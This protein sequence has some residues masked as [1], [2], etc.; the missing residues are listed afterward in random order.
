MKQALFICALTVCTWA[1][2]ANPGGGG[3]SGP[4]SIADGTT[5]ANKAWVGSA[6]EMKFNVLNFPSNFQVSNF[7][8]VQAVSQ[9]GAWSIAFSAPQH[10]ICDSGCG[11]AGDVAVVNSTTAG[12]TKLAV[13]ADPITFASTQNVN[14]ANSSIAV[15]GTFW[16]A[17]QPVSGPLTDTQLRATPVP[18]SG[19]F[20]QA[21]QPVSGPLTDAQ[22]RASSVNVNCAS[23]CSS[24]TVSQTYM[25]T[26]VGSAAA[27]SKD[28]IN[29]FNGVGSG[30]VIKLMKVAVAQGNAAAVTTGLV[31]SITM[32]KTSSAGATCTAITVRPLD[33]TNSAVPAQVTAGTNCTTD[34]TV[35]W[36]WKG[37]HIMT[38]ESAAVADEDF[39]YVYDDGGKQPITLREGEGLLLKTT[40]LNAVGA[41][42]INIEFT[43]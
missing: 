17:T 25:A 14:V 7:P 19:T 37:C 20:W 5:P 8:A 23:G 16:Q 34:P 31:A 6:G 2:I 42:T 21:T 15:T 38:E 18:V 28:L 43:M 1:Q 41:V 36:D 12:K 4:I 33:S 30:K 40:A 39:C 13:T 11:G 27:A 3:S 24:P 22:L 9:S 32:S 10:M 35:A 26:V 29:L